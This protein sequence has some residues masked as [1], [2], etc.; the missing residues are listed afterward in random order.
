MSIVMGVDP[1]NNKLKYDLSGQR[2]GR[3][4]AVKHLPGDRANIATW[5]CQCD[6]GELAEI[7]QWNLRNMFSRSC[8]CLKSAPA[9]NVAD[10]HGQIFGSLTVVDRAQSLTASGQI[11]WNCRCECGGFTITTSTKLR[12]GHS[13]SC[14]CLKTKR[15]TQSWGGSHYLRSTYRKMLQRC[16]S[17]RC[18]DYPGYGGRGIYVSDRWRFGDSRASGFQC[19][20]EDMGDRPVGRSLDRI[21]NDGPYAPDNCRWAT[22]IQ[23]ANNRRAPSR[24]SPCL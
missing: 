21:D 16:Y 6:C 1:A 4:V 12:S 2:F 11:R 13:K 14:G 24:R 7:H 19:F 23:Q 9:R 20:V 22:F 18:S 10:I 8:G 15:I 5:L 3:L 17:Q